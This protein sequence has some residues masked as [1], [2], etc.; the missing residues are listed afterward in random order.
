MSTTTTAEPRPSYLPWPCV[1]QALKSERHHIEAVVLSL[2]V[3]PILVKTPILV[4]LLSGQKWPPQTISTNLMRLYLAVLFHLR[5]DDRWD[6][7]TAAFRTIDDVLR[8][9]QQKAFEQCLGDGCLDGMASSSEGEAFTL[10]YLNAYEAALVK[11]MH[12]FRQPGDDG[13]PP[14]PSD[15]VLKLSAFGDDCSELRGLFTPCVL[16]DKLTKELEAEQEAFSV[17][18]SML[19]TALEENAAAASAAATAEKKATPLPG[20][21]KPCHCGSGKKYKKCHRTKDQAN[22]AEERHA[23]DLIRKLMANV[24]VSDGS[25]DAADDEGSTTSES[26]SS[27]SKEVDDDD[28]ET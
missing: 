10:A 9:D 15:E 5:T 25:G 24:E 22:A 27:A 18:R 12:V 1:Q 13:K 8:A 26:S 20:P 2:P 19:D 16:A 7:D 28:D 17:A 3:T 11:V 14:V 6:A 4:G 23:V 21:N